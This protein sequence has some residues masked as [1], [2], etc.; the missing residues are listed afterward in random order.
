MLC[1]YC[2]SALNN[3][4]TACPNCGGIGGSPVPSDASAVQNSDQVSA[5][6]LHQS[7]SFSD[8][9]PTAAESAI[10][11]VVYL[12]VGLMVPFFIPLITYFFLNKGTTKAYATFMLIGF[13]IQ[14]CIELFFL[15]A[16]VISEFC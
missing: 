14:T 8:E 3:G 10:I 12:V 15:A 6:G 7:L 4:E 5:D 13:I 1:Q 2:G 9:P 11:K 16:A